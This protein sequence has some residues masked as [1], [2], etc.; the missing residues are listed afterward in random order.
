MQKI[1]IPLSKC[2]PGMITAQPIINLETGTTI[3]G[4]NIEITSEHIKD[5][6]HFIYSDIWVYLDSSSKVWNLSSETIEKYKAYSDALN[7]VVKNLSENFA[8]DIETFEQLCN[9][10][11]IDFKEN[12]SLLG[13]THLIKSLSYDTY[14]HSLNVSLLCILLCRWLHIDHTTLNHIIKAALLHDVGSI[15]LPFDSSKILEG[16]SPEEE[17]EYE[18][19]PIYSYNIVSKMQDIDS[20]VS[21]AIL[22]HHEYLDGSGYP[23]HIKAPYINTITRIL[24]IADTY[25]LLMKKH[26][27]FD[28]LQI[29]LEEYIT[30]LDADKL[31][32]FCNFISTY[33]LGVFVT[34][35]NGQI[36]QVVFINPKCLYRPIIKIN[37]TFINLYEES[38]LKIISIE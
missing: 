21:K 20:L 32:T 24:S 23:I 17:M 4:Q 15:N 7:T 25:E 38:S 28:T 8:I 11:S 9:H 5:F 30:R 27:I 22:A 6:S 2:I 3:L 33:Y 12:H 35:S 13:C 18:K 31:L 14:T 34:L 36:G 10:L 16:L 19:H 37:D 26:H 1:I 29:L